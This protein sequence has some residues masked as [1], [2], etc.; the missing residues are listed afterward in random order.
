MRILNRFIFF[1]VNFFGA[2]F[3]NYIDIVFLTKIIIISFVSW[4]RFKI[5]SIIKLLFI[6]KNRY[7]GF[8]IIIPGFFY[9]GSVTLMKS[10]HCRNKP[11]GATFI[12]IGI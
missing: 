2:W 11:D 3:K 10:S 8:L 9:K 5:L 7:D 1:R 6:N 4:I 12:S